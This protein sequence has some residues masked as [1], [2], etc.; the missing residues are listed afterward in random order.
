MAT[1]DHTA[2]YGPGLA[3]DYYKGFLERVMVA[4]EENTQGVQDTVIGEQV[5]PRLLGDHLYFAAAK[6]RTFSK[7]H[8]DGREF[9]CIK[10]FVFFF[11]S[12]PNYDPDTQLQVRKNNN[13]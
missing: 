6:L 11:P 13:Q 9:Q 12:D 8:N 3:T 5:H 4:A 7:L 10:Q 1:E 2:G